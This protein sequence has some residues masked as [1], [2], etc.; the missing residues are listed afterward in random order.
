MGLA[1]LTLIAC[2]GT[3][4]SD[5]DADFAETAG[6]EAA[7]CRLTETPIAAYRLPVLPTHYDLLEPSHRE[8]WDLVQAVLEQ[9]APA[10]PSGDEATEE[11]IQS[12]ANGPYT[13]FLGAHREA[14][15]NAETALNGLADENPDVRVV[16]STLVALM[17]YHMA[18]EMLAAPVPPS[19]SEDPALTS[20]YLAAIQHGVQPILD[21]A[22]DRAEYCVYVASSVPELHRWRVYCY[23]LIGHTVMQAHHVISMIREAEHE[24]RT[25]EYLVRRW[26]APRAGTSLGAHATVEGGLTGHAVSSYVHAHETPLLACYHRALDEDETLHGQVVLGFDIGADGAVSNVESTVSTLGRDDVSACLTRAVGEFSFPAPTEGAATH[27]SV[28]IDLRVIPV[29]SEEHVDEMAGGHHEN[30]EDE[31][32]AEEGAAEEGAAEAAPAE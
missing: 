14:L 25:T 12:Y 23:A 26:G 15:V 21:T 2:G 31:G 6:G 13:A 5:D 3:T 27:A 19:V 20:S 22:T 28:A 7:A 9:S 8:P 30:V 24:S 4:P 29:S 32:A 10:A 16:A 17:Y 11:A 18:V 1:A